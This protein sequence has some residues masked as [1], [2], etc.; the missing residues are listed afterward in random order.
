[1][2]KASLAIPWFGAELLRP[3]VN[4]TH[5]PRRPHLR[6]AGFALALLALG[7]CAGA[8]KAAQLLHRYVNALA[9][10]EFEL[11][12]QAIAMQREAFAHADLLPLYG[13]SELVKRI[14][15]KASLFFKS[16]PTDFEVF[17]VGK[18]GATSLIILQ[19]L[20]AIGPELRG[21][22]IAISIS[23]SWFFTERMN[24]RYYN[25]NF[26]SAQATAL[27]F[28]DTLSL[29]LRRRA[30]RRMLAFPESLKNSSVLR[31]ALARLAGDS[32]M[33]R[34]G[35]FLVA[36]L[37]RV[38]S[39]VQRMQ[40]EMECALFVLDHH[41]RF[42]AGSAHHPLPI[43]WEAE[44]APYAG[45]E[46]EREVARVRGSRSATDISFQVT[47]AHATEWTDLTLLLQGLKELGAQPLLLTMPI[48]GQY[49]DRIGVRRS[50][51]DQY[52]QHV[53]AL[54]AEFGVPLLDFEEHEQDPGFLV[55]HHD[56]LSPEGWMFF[57]KALDDFFHCRIGGRQ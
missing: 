26:S 29:D 22:K 23:P 38:Q 36:P 28:S 48:N 5:Q 35:F 31:F 46:A 25:G 15:D 47:M 13:S 2:N 51:R 55:D 7:M 21:K 49:Y 10:M 6:A 14:P 57:D 18:A 17:A 20:A 24:P 50:S 32:P 52:V 27:I 8:A 37:A 30:A 54:A 33:D 56:H 19:K 42:R 41:T 1:M 45:S 34:A 40:D 4:E 43:D 16:Y 9:P 44:L 11:K 53:R 3:L 39:M 12:G